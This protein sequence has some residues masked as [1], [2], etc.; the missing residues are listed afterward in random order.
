MKLTAVAIPF[1]VTAAGGINLVNEVGQEVIHFQF[2]GFSFPVDANVN[3]QLSDQIA[4][5]INNGNV[6]LTPTQT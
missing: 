3:Q 4:A 2:I 1:T 6:T 5:L